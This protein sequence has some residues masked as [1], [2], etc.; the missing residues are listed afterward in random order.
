MESAY[1][2]A[3]PTRRRM[4]PREVTDM[5][6]AKQDVRTPS[7]A[8]QP[9]AG[10][11]DEMPPRVDVFEPPN[12]MLIGE[13]RLIIGTL[14]HLT[15][16]QQGQAST[17]EPEAGERAGAAVSANAD[18]D[19]GTSDPRVTAEE[20]TILTLMANGLTLDSVAVRVSISPRTLS[21]RLRCVCDR[22]GVAFP[23]QAIVW[24]ARQG[25]I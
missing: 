8:Y 14:S 1:L 16:A 19:G 3:C 13:A 10:R 18:N 6:R 4:L 21:R 11:R 24:A 2:E 20:L 25:L 7:A 5:N 17:P 15:I 23:I 12:T 9:A 22:L